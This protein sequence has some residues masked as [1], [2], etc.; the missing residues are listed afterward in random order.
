M[1][2][3][4]PLIYVQPHG[5][6]AVIHRSEHNL[7]L[8]VHSD[9]DGWV[10]YMLKEQSPFGS[11]ASQG[12]M[13]GDGDIQQ[14]QLKT[15]LCFRRPRQHAAC[16]SALVCLQI[17]CNLQSKIHPVY[18]RGF[19]ERTFLAVHLVCLQSHS[20]FS[21]SNVFCTCFETNATPMHSS[22]LCCWD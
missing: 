6:H 15:E 13:G 14:Q 19:P 20:S 17:E 4:A 11:L 18:S 5:V 10:C 21:Q 8:L 2:I 16:F 1:A 12:G 9:L 7:C 3:R 22:D